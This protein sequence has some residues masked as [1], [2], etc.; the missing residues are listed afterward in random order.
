METTKQNLRSHDF[1]LF[2]FKPILVFVQLTY[3]YHFEISF[4]FKRLNK[5]NL[6]VLHAG[7]MDY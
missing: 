6:K 5:N 7:R 3:F 2:N 4:D 1:S